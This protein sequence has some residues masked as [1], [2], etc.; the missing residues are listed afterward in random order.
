MLHEIA[1]VFSQSINLLHLLP[2]KTKVKDREIYTFDIYFKNVFFLSFYK[3]QIAVGLDKQRL[4][5]FL[6]MLTLEVELQPSAQLSSHSVSLIL[7]PYLCFF[8]LFQNLVDL[9]G[10]ERAS[11]TGAFG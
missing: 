7:L 11:Q 8:L 2:I 1:F 3:D 10:S 5:E 6:L 9:A 4:I